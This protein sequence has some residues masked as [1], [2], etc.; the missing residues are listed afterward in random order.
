MYIIN[1]KA[2][3][4][5]LMD[6]NPTNLKIILQWY[7]NEE[8]KFATGLEGNVGLYQLAQMY[9]NAEQSENN[10]W[11]G[12]FIL[13][14]GEMIGI[15]KGQIKKAAQISLWI[16]TLI[17]DKPYQNKGYGKKTV[18]LLI[19]YTKLKS[20][21]SV[22]FIAVSELNTKGY[23]FWESLGFEHFV[24]VDNCIKFGE[25][26]SNAIIMYKPV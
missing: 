26:S 1:T 24:R 23:K 21:V 19:N 5:Y 16:N 3:D 8:F 13:S 10:F 7:N 6:I 20:N 2:E 17:I 14:T 12:I 25:E 4:V 22:V 11:A 18:N 15:L 9:N